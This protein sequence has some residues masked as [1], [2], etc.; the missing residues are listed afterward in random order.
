MEASFWLHHSTQLYCQTLASTCD[1]RD[2]R[3]DNSERTL[4]V[5]ADDDENDHGNDNAELLTLASGMF[6]EPMGS[7]D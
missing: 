1:S 6:L 7:E 2:H 5:A 3:S 4:H